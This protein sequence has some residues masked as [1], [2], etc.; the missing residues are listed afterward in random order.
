MRLTAAR[1]RCDLGKTGEIA[2]GAV[3]RQHSSGRVTLHTARE[4]GVV[5]LTEIPNWNSV[6]ETDSGVYA[7]RSFHA[8]TALTNRARRILCMVWSESRV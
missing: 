6:S 2:I 4:V 1:C 5:S 3:D 7:Q 8:E